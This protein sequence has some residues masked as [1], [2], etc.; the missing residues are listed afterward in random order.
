MKGSSLRGLQNI[1]KQKVNLWPFSNLHQ[2]YVNL[3]VSMRFLRSL[4]AHIWHQLSISRSRG[5][6]GSGA[7]ESK[8]PQ[9]SFVTLDQCCCVS[10]T[11]CLQ[12]KL[13]S[14]LGGSASAQQV[15]KCTTSIQVADGHWK[16][17][18]FLK[19]VFSFLA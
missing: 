4:S 2:V 10:L 17:K 9:L 5:N 18:A 6:L 8:E 16:T 13:L 19:Y 3:T 1:H 11:W 12:N 15:L 7:E 14:S